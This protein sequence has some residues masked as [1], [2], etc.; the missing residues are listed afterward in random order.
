MSK[1]ILLR[2][3]FS[4]IVGFKLVSVDVNVVVAVV[5]TSV[6]GTNPFISWFVWL[7]DVPFSNASLVTIFCGWM[8]VGGD[9]SEGT[10]ES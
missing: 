9:V 4:S 3:I 5:A 1:S 8:A 2:V 10:A 7:C 6:V